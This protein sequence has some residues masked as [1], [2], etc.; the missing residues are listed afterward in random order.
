MRNRDVEKGMGKGVCC[1]IDLCVFLVL[2]TSFDIQA[3]YSL[4][5][6]FELFFLYFHRSKPKITQI[7]PYFIIHTNHFILEIINFLFPHERIHPLPLHRPPNHQAPPNRT[8]QT[9]P[10][11]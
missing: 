11:R 3:A 1:S 10:K 9:S 6:F 7:S 5:M 2:I 8:H 4:Y